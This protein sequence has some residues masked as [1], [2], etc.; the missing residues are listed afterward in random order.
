MKVYFL[1]NN[2]N[3]DVQIRAKK[4]WDNLSLFLNN[5]SSFQMRK[6]SFIMGDNN[7]GVFWYVVRKINE[8]NLKKWYFRLQWCYDK[9]VEIKAVLIKF[10]NHNTISSSWKI[11]IDQDNLWFFCIE[12]DPK[13]ITDKRSIY[14][15]VLSIEDRKI[16]FGF[17]SIKKGVMIRKEAEKENLI[18]LFNSNFLAA[19]ESKIRFTYSNRK[20]KI[21]MKLI[22]Y[23][24]RNTDVENFAIELKKLWYAHSISL[25]I[26]ETLSAINFLKYCIKL[27]FLKRIDLEIKNHGD[28]YEKIE[29]AE[30]ISNLKKLQKDVKIRISAIILSNF[31]EK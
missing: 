26:D 5:I 21:Q 19:S 12:L 13:C 29:L 6:T 8:F 7:E 27:P 20:W 4:S 18:Y 30:T 28:L 15:E 23:T 17:N 3:T 22:N 11:T 1:F 24:V 25:T 9:L 14:N 2:D 31:I 16:E 10:K